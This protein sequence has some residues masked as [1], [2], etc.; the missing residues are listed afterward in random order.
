MQVRERIGEA[1]TLMKRERTRG[2]A[3]LNEIFRSG[4]APVQ[5]LDG[6]YPGK[7]VAL[8]I[9]QTIGATLC[10]SYPIHFGR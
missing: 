6:S 9:A 5:P 10:E 8:D 4:A 3:T 7:L 1:R 2:L